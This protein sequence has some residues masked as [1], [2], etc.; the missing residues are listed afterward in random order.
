MP[1]SAEET[2][3]GPSLAVGLC[4]RGKKP[5]RDVSDCPAPRSQGVCFSAALVSDSRKRTSPEG[6]GGRAVRA[7]TSHQQHHE[8]LRCLEPEGRGDLDL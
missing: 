1:P 6:G 2:S 8:L 4:G 5:R 3:A 7:V